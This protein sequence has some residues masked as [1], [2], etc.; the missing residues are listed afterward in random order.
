MIL[1]FTPALI[2]NSRVGDISRQLRAEGGGAHD[3]SVQIAFILI[4]VAAIGLAWVFYRFYSRP[5]ATVNT[6]FGMLAEISRAHEISPAGRRLLERIAERA[7]LDQP[8][9]LTIGTE[10]FDQAVAAA[11]QRRRLDPR[12]RERLKQIRKRLFAE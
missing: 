5:P 11:E 3:W 1:T 8:A 7:E 2:A 4:P 6:P 12:E 10:P 9:R